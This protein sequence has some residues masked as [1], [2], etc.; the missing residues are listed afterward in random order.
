MRPTLERIAPYLLPPGLLLLVAGGF[1]ALVTQRF[2]LITNVLFGGGA[3]LFL[4]YV[5]LRPDDLRRLLSG[6]RAR[7]GTIALLSTLLFAVAAVLIYY[8]VFNNDDWRLDL[9]ASNEFTPLDETRALLADLQEPIRVIAFIDPSNA[10]VRAEVIDVLDG[11][12]A[13]SEL[14]SYEF[15][16]PTELPEAVDRYELSA[17]N[18]LV[19]TRGSG[20]DEVFSKSVV[21]GII[22]DADIHTALLRVINPV[23]KV[24]Y[25][26]TGHGELDLLDPGEL[27]VSSMKLF[28]ENQG[29]TVNALELF[30]AGAVPADADVVALVGQQT[31]M[32]PEE[33]AALQAYLDQ[34]GGLL[35]ARDVYD[36]NDLTAADNDGLGPLLTE[37]W[38]ITLR[39]DVVIDVQQAQAGQ[40]SVDVNFLITDFGTSPI[41]SAD[42]RDLGSVAFA[43]R[44]VATT[45]VE[46]VIQTVLTR[47]SA[48]SWGESDF[49]GLASGQVAPDAG[50]DAVGPVP[51]AV[52]AENSASGARLVVVGDADFMTNRDAVARGNYLFGSNALNWLAGD[53]GS[54]TLTPR[55]TVERQLFIPETR[56]TIVQLLALCFGPIAIILIGFLVWFSRRSRR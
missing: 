48:N 11:L 33:V 53:E 29:F 40:A 24:A 7:Y 6:S 45:E 21:G 56:L 3:L 55:D 8:V 26:V 22:N 46:G 4:A 54:I 1:S 16:D 49:T 27:G 25:F 52:S 19:F 13:E 35:V 23:N 12:R 36:P 34:G 10:A 2:G 30:T 51:L 28:L 44:S 18:T 15:R 5:V 9:T 32:S 17:A 42:L 31:P 14:L 39:P 41:I 37:R 38:G 50:V 20:A 43:A 47:S